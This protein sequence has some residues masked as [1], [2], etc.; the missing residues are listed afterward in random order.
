LKSDPLTASDV[1]TTAFWGVVVELVMLWFASAA[2]RSHCR[3]LAG[4]RSAG[5]GAAQR[6]ESVALLASSELAVIN[7]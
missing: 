6:R 3:S 1:L 4:R 5:R 7:W 2:G